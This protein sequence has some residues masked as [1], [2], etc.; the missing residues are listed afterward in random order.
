V[1]AA[2]P[3]GVGAPPR[4]WAARCQGQGTARRGATLPKRGR[5]PG[6]PHA[7]QGR[8]APLGGR[9]ARRGGPGRVHGEGQ[10]C[11]PG[12]GEGEGESEKKG[13][14]PWDPKIGDNRHRIT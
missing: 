1:G 5:A 13:S 11:A 6:E 9:A 2:L 12:K 7:G 10:G 8:A 14:S 3:R 4:A